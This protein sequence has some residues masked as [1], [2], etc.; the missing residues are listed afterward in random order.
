[1]EGDSGGGHL[2]PRGALTQGSSGVEAALMRVEVARMEVEVLQNSARPALEAH[3]E[4]DS[5][6]RACSG[7]S[8]CRQ[9]GARATRS[10]KASR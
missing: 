3:L 8:P 4:P 5:A 2:P 1:M 10:C 7:A 6:R 9:P